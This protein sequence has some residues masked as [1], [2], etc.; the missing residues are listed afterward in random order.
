MYR[1]ERHLT[2]LTLLCS[3]CVLWK[4]SERKVVTITGS[5][6]A[7]FYNTHWTTLFVIPKITE[8]NFCLNTWK[9]KQMLS[10]K[11]IHSIK[12]ILS[13]VSINRRRQ[14]NLKDGAISC[15][16]VKG[17][18]I[19]MWKCNHTFKSAINCSW[20]PDIWSSYRAKQC[21]DLRLFTRQNQHLSLVS[22][23]N[24]W[25]ESHVF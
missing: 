7:Y 21:W 20:A 23:L 13:S 12:K 22:T 24:E 6:Q 4:K 25:E 2:K 17:W 16:V 3:T 9:I 11:Y 14:W 5:N 15:C 10:L 1:N 18:R 19:E 8:N